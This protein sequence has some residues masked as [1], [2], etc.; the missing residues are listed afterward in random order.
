MF[1]IYFYS[2]IF[3]LNTHIY[4]FNYYTFY[5]YSVIILNFFFY[6]LL[7]LLVFS[8]LFLFDTSKLKALSDF[9]GL[10]NYLFLGFSFFLSLF[11]LAGIP[12]LSGFSIKLLTFM[13]LF[14]YNNYIILFFFIFLNFFFLF[15]YV[16]N[17]RILATK[18]TTS[19]FL[20]YKNRN[21]LSYN[22][23]LIFVILCLNTINLMTICFLE[24]LVLFFNFIASFM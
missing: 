14:L 7:L 4:L 10:N 5:S 12:P 11:S 22:S 3:L 20:F 16:Q 6:T 24:D 21:F 18:T 19:Y 8:I 17:S 9:K 2:F 23:F 15:F 13:L 1:E